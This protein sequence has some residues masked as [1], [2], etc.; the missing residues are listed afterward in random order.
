SS[1]IALPDTASIEHVR[2]SACYA[3]ATQAEGRLHARTTRI[4]RWLAGSCT[5]R[6]RP[7]RLRGWRGFGGYSNSN[8]HRHTKGN[9][10][11]HADAY[12]LQHERQTAAIVAHSVDPDGELTK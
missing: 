12:G 10:H 5:R 6:V 7:Y 2:C 11:A 3:E 1:S 4:C 9:L 8:H